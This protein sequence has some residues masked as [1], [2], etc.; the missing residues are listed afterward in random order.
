MKKS[1]A[2]YTLEEKAWV[3]MKQ[4]EAEYKYHKCYGFK[5][6]ALTVKGEL[7]IGLVKSKKGYS[8]EYLERDGERLTGLVLDWDLQGRAIENHADL[9]LGTVQGGVSTI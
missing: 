8:A 4:A 2:D 3:A 7:V 9:R 1:P 5:N 6:M